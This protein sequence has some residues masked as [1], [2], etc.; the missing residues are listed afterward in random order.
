MTQFIEYLIT[1]PPDSD[2]FGRKE[3]TRYNMGISTLF[4]CLR[5]I[6]CDY[7]I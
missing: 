7:E 6:L 2:E 1:T 5:S 4:D 3:Y